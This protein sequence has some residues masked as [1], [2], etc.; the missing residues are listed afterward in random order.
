MRAP[1]CLDAI[2]RHPMACTRLASALTVSLTN[3]ILPAAWSPS[4]LGLLRELL[5]A[6]PKVRAAAVLRGTASQ[7]DSWVAML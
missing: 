2:L 3:P 6:L 7:G 5:C 4:M 1:G